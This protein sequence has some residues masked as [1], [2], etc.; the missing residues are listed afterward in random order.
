MLYFQD[1]WKYIMFLKC[2]QLQEQV[3]QLTIGL[4]RLKNVLTEIHIR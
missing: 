1:V 4:F 2:N 3:E